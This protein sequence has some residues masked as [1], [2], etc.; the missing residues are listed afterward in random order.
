[1][2]FRFEKYMVEVTAIFSSVL[3]LFQQSDFEVPGPCGS[4]SIG[5]IPTVLGHY[6]VF[7]GTLFLSSTFLIC[8]QWQ[9]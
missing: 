3:L 8:T 1:M 7:T 5:L 9:S 6:L 2:A 4:L